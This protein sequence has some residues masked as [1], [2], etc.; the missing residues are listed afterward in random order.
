MERNLVR[1]WLF[2]L[3]CGPHAEAQGPVL[4]NARNDKAAQESGFV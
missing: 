3:R 2:V 4:V 1:F